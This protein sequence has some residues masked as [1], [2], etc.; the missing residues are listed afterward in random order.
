MMQEP[1]PRNRNHRAP[2]DGCWSSIHTRS[3]RYSSGTRASYMGM[4]RPFFFFPPFLSPL[5]LL[6]REQERE[7]R[8]K[9]RREEKRRKES[10]TVEYTNDNQ[11]PGQRHVSH[12]GNP[13][14]FDSGFPTCALFCTLRPDC[15]AQA[16]LPAVSVLPGRQRQH[17]GQRSSPQSPH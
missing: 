13:A 4:A 8:K 6:K 16:C 11:R 10:K 15:S 2:T 17:N 7:R 14:G 1:S 12:A 3:C 5:R 9:T